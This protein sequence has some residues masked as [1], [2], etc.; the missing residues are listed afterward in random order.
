MRSRLDMFDAGLVSVD[1]DP[2]Q[3]RE[4]VT[5][6]IREDT[7][8]IA[9][10]PIV[11]MRDGSIVGAEALSRFPPSPL[12][13]PGAWFMA[14]EQVGL[15]LDLEVHSARRDLALT[16][17]SASS[18]LLAI[19]VSPATVIAGLP[20]LLGE[21][22]PWHRLVF[23]LT[24][25]VPVEDY[26][27]L[28]AALGQLRTRG[29]RVAVDDAGAGFAS[30]RHIA[31]LSPDIIKLDIGIT[32][33]VDT[34]PSRAAIAEML[35]T[36]AQRMG[37]RVIAEGVETEAERDVLVGLGLDWGQGFLLGRPEIPD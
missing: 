5:S 1:D 7:V 19:N 13:H 3:V 31:N 17:S 34:D 23:E 6:A 37:V 26:T 20:H 27:T 9:L 36:F 2:A 29:A 24:E 16:A 8:R 33:G 4:L 32:R 11:D 14:A 28:V 30:F 35:S 25:H 15:S 21:D 18:G 12:P 10:Q 22:V